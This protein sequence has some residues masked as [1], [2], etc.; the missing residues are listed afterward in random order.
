MSPEQI[1]Q[2]KIA[3]GLDTSSSFI[4]QSSSNMAL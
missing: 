4:T 2:N 1:T 3:V